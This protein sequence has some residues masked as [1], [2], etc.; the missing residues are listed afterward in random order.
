VR[1]DRQPHGHAERS[2]RAEGLLRLQLH[3][4][5]QSGA[6]GNQT[7]R[8]GTTGQPPGPRGVS[9]GA[10]MPGAGSWMGAHA[11]V[12]GCPG[13]A[14]AAVL[15]LA[16]TST[17]SG[18]SASGV[19]RVR[20]AVPWIPRGVGRVTP[21]WKAPR[22]ARARRARRTG[23]SGTYPEDLKYTQEHE[24]ARIEGDRAVIGITD[25]AQD[26]R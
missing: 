15:G 1:R 24:W 8:A 14:A 18:R 16:P 19:V 23:M 17:R 25:Y 10:R 11:A 20:P 21:A 4:L 13:A 6:P 12:A 9:R 5:E 2:G 22:P 7:G 26:A 3:S